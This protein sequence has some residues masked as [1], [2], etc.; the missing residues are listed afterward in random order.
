MELGTSLGINTAY[1]ALNKDTKVYSFEGDQKVAKLAAQHLASF[2]NCKLIRGNIDNTLVTFL[3]D[4]EQALD[5]V[6]F[7]ANHTYEATLRYFNLCL[8]HAHEHSIFILDDIY[9]SR[10]MTKA[11]KEIKKHPKVIASVD[12]FD[13]GILF[14][15]P[16]LNRE[17]LIL[18]F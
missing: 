8:P 4:Y 10:G 9:W 11:W 18:D 1:L 12:I 16:S 2:N 5:L 6:Y 7:D 3:A 15:D 14:F 17:N 13:A